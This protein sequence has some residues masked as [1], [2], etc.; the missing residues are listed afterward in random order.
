MTSRGNAVGALALAGLIA[1]CGAKGTDAPGVGKSNGG[2]GTTGDGHGDASGGGGNPS[3]GGLTGG[4]P[5]LRATGGGDN[6]TGGAA[7]PDGGV[8]TISDSDLEELRSGR[9]S[10][11]SATSTLLPASLMLVVDASLSMGETSATSGGRT[12]WDITV[13]ALTTALNALPPETQVGLLL[14]PNTQQNVTP[15]DVAR[16]VSACVNVGAM[17]PP[18]PLGDATGG[19]R[20]ALITT[21]ESARLTVYTPTHDALATGYDAFY[22]SGLTGSGFVLLIT[23]GEPNVLRGCICSNSGSEGG[24]YENY[25]PEAIIAETQ[26]AYSQGILTYF[27]GS[28][29]SETAREWLS[30]AAE[31]GGTAYAGCSS[32][33]PS[34]CHFDMTTQADFSTALN[35]ALAQIAGS[36]ISCSYP[37]PAPPGDSTIDP[38]KVNVVYTTDAG[39]SVLLLRNDQPNC[40]VGWQYTADG[41]GI[42]LCSAT[43][44]TATQDSSAKVEL[45]FGCDTKIK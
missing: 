4:S 11:W 39:G 41:T 19:Q 31:A 20:Q 35:D 15:S 21:L 13:E 1:A 14:Y 10:D 8:A 9:C 5:G 24:R 28:P 2:S 32:T 37:I 17:V 26:L 29:G 12:K 25:D 22:Q 33:G 40:D 34:Y 27:I 38:N 16:D 45:F 42:N 7:D 43:C 23:D 6:G 30:R 18:A 44:E 36:V 3:S